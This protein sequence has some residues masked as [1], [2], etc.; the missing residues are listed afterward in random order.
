MKGHIHRAAVCEQKLITAVLTIVQFLHTA[1]L[2]RTL[3]SNEQ[4]RVPLI[5]A[6]CLDIGLKMRTFQAH[7]YESITYLTCSR[8]NSTQQRAAEATHFLETS[9]PDNTEGVRTLTSLL[10]YRAYAPIRGSEMNDMGL[11]EVNCGLP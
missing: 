11:G 9:T 8:D 3:L 7:L 5:L 10:F 4:K 1:Q 2:G 6:I